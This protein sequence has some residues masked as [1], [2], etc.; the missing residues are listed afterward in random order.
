VREHEGRVRLLGSSSGGL[1]PAVAPREQKCHAH[2]NNER[3]DPNRQE[4][5]GPAAEVVDKD[6]EA[7]QVQ[8]QPDGALSR[9]YAHVRCLLALYNE[10]R[11]RT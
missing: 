8:C 7:Q 1:A 4:P 5:R 10:A 3:H 9:L 11:A 6:D 2:P